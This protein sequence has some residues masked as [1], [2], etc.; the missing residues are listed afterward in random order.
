MKQLAVVGAGA[1]GLAVAWWAAAAGWVVTVYDPEPARGASW[2]AGGMLAASSEGWP[3]EE[4]LLALSALSLA[5]WPEF[6]KRLVAE[7][8]MPSGLRTDGMVI[9]GMDSADAKE[10]DV[11]ANWLAENG[12]PVARLSG[13]EL[14]R[15]EP[16]LSQGIRA[17]LDVPDDLAVDN[18]ALLAALQAACAVSGV[19]VVRERVTDPALLEADQ[20]VISAGVGA[21]ALHAMARVRAVKG[22]ILRVRSR[23]GVLPSPGRTVR[24]LVYGRRVYLVPR[25]DGLVVGATQH[26]VGH[27]REVTIGGVRDLIA[28]AET[29]LPTIAE[30]ELVSADAGLRPMSPDNLPLIGR[31]DART[32]LA[33][34]HGRNGLLLAP[35]TAE[36]VLAELDG[37]PLPEVAAAHP[38]RFA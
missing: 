24:G 21:S 1:I 33:T 28:D 8:G 10:L 15:H 32:V 31:V 14:R 4:E 23:A 12:R 36:A 6:A 27:D 22:E 26:E 38:R 25:D 3:G 30:Y 11:L 2:V 17:A 34:G 5:R 16:A 29:V 7:S 9:V 13:R 20:V 35:I 18:R 19:R 37:R